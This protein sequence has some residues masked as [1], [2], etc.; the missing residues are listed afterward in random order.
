MTAKNFSGA[1]T[2]TRL[3][4]LSAYGILDTGPE[5][6][7]DDAVRL[8]SRLCAAP[9][10]LVSLVASDR[11]WFKAR[12]G[13]PVG[14]TDLDRSVCIHALDE[15]DLL[16][17][18]DLTQDPRTR[19]NPLVTGA[20]AIRFYAGAPLR[21]P[22]GHVIGSLCVI[23]T[24]PRPQGLTPE[25]ADGL[26][27]LGRQVMS[28][29]ELRASR[30][31]LVES[32]AH[33]R[34]LF[35]KLDEGFVVG[36]VIRDAEQ[37]IA[38]WRTVDVNDAWGQL[39]G[40]DPRAAIGRT[41]RELIP[42]IEDA[43]IA[44]P[45]RVIDSGESQRFTRQ[46]GTLGR[47]YEGRAFKVG[48]ERFALICLEATDRVQTETRR[49]ALLA[50]GDRLRDV[51]TVSEM[52]SA[53]CEIIGRAL[54][55]TRVT[56]GA[57]DLT[58]TYVEIEPGWA[59]EG[60]AAIAGRH[61]FEDYGDLRHELLRGEPLVIEDVRHDPRSRAD[62]GPMLALEIGSLVN[63]PVRERGRTVAVLIVHDRK[64]RTWPAPVL[65]FLRNVA[66]R[67]E[68][69]V[70]RVRAEEQQRVLNEE[71]SHRLKNTLAMVQAIA[72]QTLRTVSEREPVEAFDKRIQALGTAHDVLLQD[73]WTA[74]SLKT[75]VAAVLGT[76]GQPGRFTIE[77]GDIALGP[78]ATLSVSMLLHELGTN[79][80]K[81][82]A[83]SGE[84]GRVNV[85]W[86]EEPLGGEPNVV[87]SWAESGGPPVSEPSRKGFGSRLIRMGLVGTGGV[88]LSY[89]ATGFTARMSAALA[90]LQ[91]L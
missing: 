21:T 5:E 44:E 89:P 90:Q 37:R 33:W 63:M 52:T 10:A 11:Q 9:T 53:A 4:A 23:D 49:N 29:I 51:T 75:V 58:T 88:S 86:R 83:L 66:D 87:L 3:A 73:N 43:W 77:G 48:P 22:D 71:L 82:G 69:A 19:A 2:D 30:A 85:S 81:Y 57:V 65:G 12:I 27:A 6:G 72:A 42:G 47:W 38:D 54:E 68:V 36:Q 13:F 35:E 14:E 50:L 45:A 31:R 17:I 74:A 1:G 15:P 64:P 41:I 32:E 60:V 24:V 62:P 78:R 70:A 25:Q 46:I 26:R 7:Y 79:A 39:V 34:G 84:S 28:L 61:R 55:T 76:F 67:I 8:A 56:F 40:I 91:Q 16:V 80:F 18:P 20:P 59:E